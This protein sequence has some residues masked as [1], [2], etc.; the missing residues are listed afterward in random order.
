[1]NNWQTNYE[2]ASGQP[3][4]DPAQ[5]NGFGDRPKP[6]AGFV[7]SLLCFPFINTRNNVWIHLLDATTYEQ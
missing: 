5:G 3:Y 1:M 7:L 4:Y 2:Y 6:S